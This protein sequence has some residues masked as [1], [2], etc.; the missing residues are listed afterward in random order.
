MNVTRRR[1]DET[2]RAAIIEISSWG[3]RETVGHPAP[4][5]D[6]RTRNTRREPRRSLLPLAAGFVLLAAGTIAWTLRAN[7]S[8]AT[9]VPATHSSPP[10]PTRGAGGPPFE[11]RLTSA[12]KLP[13]VEIT[14]SDA[15]QVCVLVTNLSVTDEHCFDAATVAMGWAYG[16]AGTAGGPR[17]AFGVVPDEV[18][19]VLVGEDPAQLVGNVW[20]TDITP[21]GALTLVV[22]DSVAQRWSHPVIIDGPDQPPTTSPA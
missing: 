22:G 4:H 5:S 3:S 13:A 10:R 7:G 19:T 1:S 9:L 18:D 12:G 11:F 14:S 8:P 2:I 17:F 20:A 6:I 21:A 15:T 16:I